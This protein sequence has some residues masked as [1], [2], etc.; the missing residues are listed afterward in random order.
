MMWGLHRLD[1]NNSKQHHENSSILTR[2]EERVIKLDDRLH[3][4]ISWHNHIPIAQS[5]AARK[6]VK[7]EVR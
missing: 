1:K 2:I 4:H 3:D 5:K 7:H 6:R